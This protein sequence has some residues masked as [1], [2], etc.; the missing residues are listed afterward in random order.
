MDTLASVEVA[1][2]GY[3]LW[4]DPV[5]A[6]LQR[7]LAEHLREAGVA[8]EVVLPEMNSAE[9]WELN[10]YVERFAHVTGSSPE[11]VVVELELSVVRAR[12][13]DVLLRERYRVERAV[14]DSGA[15]GAAAEL[16]IATGEVFDR[17]IADLAATGG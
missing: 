14:Q 13:G 12:T 4:V 15:A 3:Q 7:A 5:P 8:D 10:G 11:Q 2:Y 1:P 17:F 6:L 16:G 9:T